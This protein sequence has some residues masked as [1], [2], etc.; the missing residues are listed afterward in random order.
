MRLIN[1]KNFKFSLLFLLTLVANCTFS[2]TKTSTEKEP[3]LI[4]IEDSLRE[5]IKGKYDSTWMENNLQLQQRILNNHGI[6]YKLVK[7]GKREFTEGPHA[8]YTF[9]VNKKHYNFKFGDSIFQL[10][11]E[12]IYTY[13]GNSS[14]GYFVEY[15]FERV[16]PQRISFFCKHGY[17]TRQTIE[18]DTCTS[19]IDR[20]VDPISIKSNQHGPPKCKH[21]WDLTRGQPCEGC[22]LDSKIKLRNSNTCEHG[23]DIN[24]GLACS[25]C[26][27]SYK[28]QYDSSYRINDS[29]KRIKIQIQDCAHGHICCQVK[30]PC[31]PDGYPEGYKFS[32]PQAT[33]KRK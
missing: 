21:G 5:R 18:R 26:L 4:A 16:Y 32:P 31:C 10:S 15:Q 12:K 27:H 3:I 8:N 23:W 1:K 19:E 7:I 13:I 17:N 24:R 25:Q 30:S 11:G 33:K 14:W 20:T 9:N 2:Q 29:L 6:Y 28:M 22:R